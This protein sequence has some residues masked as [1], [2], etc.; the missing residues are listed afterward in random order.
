[1]INLHEIQFYHI[2]I[3]IFQGFTFFKYKKM[4]FG[5]EIYKKMVSEWREAYLDYNTL[6]TLLKPFNMMA[7]KYLKI[8]LP[9]TISNHPNMQTN[10]M[11]TNYSQDDIEKLIEFSEKF[12]YVMNFEI[13]KVTNFFKAKLLDY[14]RRFR[15][16]KINIT[17]LESM[18]FEKDYAKL[19]GE[20]RNCFH[21]FYKEII[22]LLDFYFISHEAARKIL[23]KQKKLFSK[24]PRKF[25][26]INLDDILDDDSYLHKNIPKL[27]KLRQEVENLYLDH[28]YHI[29]TKEQGKIELNKITHGRFTSHFE[30]FLN[31]MFLG[32]STLLLAVIIILLFQGGLDPDNDAN[33]FFVFHVYRGFA[34]I[35]AYM[36]FLAWNVYG[37]TIYYVNYR[38]IFAFNYHY[39][40]LSE[41][42]K[43][44]SIFTTILMLTLLWYILIR[45][46]EDFAYILGFIPKEYSPL[47]CWVLFL[48]YLFFPS[49]KYFNGEGRR[50]F[51]KLIKN[52]FIYSFISVDFPITWATEQFISFV[53]PIRD[54]EFSICY[55]T[56]KMLSG[57]DE[58]YCSYTERL[59]LALI[60]TAFPL[61]LRIIQCLRIMYQKHHRLVFSSDFFNA[62]KYFITLITVTFSFLYS[63][64]QNSQ[65][66]FSLWVVFSILSTGYS[67][68]WDLKMD[69]GFLESVSKYKYL[70]NQL[71]YAKPAFYYSAIIINL[72]MRFCWILTLS[73]GIMGIF[74]RK[75]SFNFLFGVIEMVRR[76]I[77]NFFRVEMEHIA[78][79]GDFKV[80]ENYKLPFDNFRYNT[81]EKKMIYGEYEAFEA[82]PM[83]N[84]PKEAKKLKSM[85]TADFGS[86]KE[87]EK[88]L[89]NQ[90][91]HI[92]KKQQSN[93]SEE[94]L[95]HQKTLPK[96]LT[97]SIKNE[98]ETFK[99]TLIKNN[100]FVVT[101]DLDS[102]KEKD[103]S[104]NKEDNP[105]TFNNSFEEQK[106]KDQG[107]PNLTIY[108]NRMRN[109][110]SV[111]Y[112]RSISPENKKKSRK[113]SIEMEAMAGNLGLETG[114]NSSKFKSKI[115]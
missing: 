55:Y 88:P 79:C 90:N 11:I 100:C 41:I 7:K 33:F 26:P 75:Q 98:V 109:K 24:L 67:Y 71:S 27:H 36:W 39:S 54:I 43:R 102:S 81:D 61:L 96:F 40:T 46:D 57:K 48:G 29:N 103:K 38:N 19:K 44:T 82:T 10:L 16:I 65:L 91:S 106:E 14:L 104:S 108:S 17:I 23:K 50:Y 12:E 76:A 30:N 42:V 34:L 52:L 13:Q 3:F 25:T 72:F 74:L 31:G 37:W 111:V 73:P 84:K 77:W 85:K 83:L 58:L 6:K 47:I 66:Y 5:H 2:I 56:E 45:E 63:L 115:N 101:E 86:E 20:L 22:L 62:F 32:F 114:D 78:N 15:L 87:I 105:V 18:N 99:K 35:L 4:K 70:R 69:W 92:E 49:F 68:F 110:Q 53:I 60:A 107:K 112:T 94:I 1:L 93:H 21:L 95:S 28:F 89:L 8:P 51:F 9:P 113:L 64:E 59:S 80:V 97:E